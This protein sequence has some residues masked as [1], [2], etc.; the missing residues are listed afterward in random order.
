[1]FWYGGVSPQG[2]LFCVSIRKPQHESHAY[3][4]VTVPQNWTMQFKVQLSNTFPKFS[5]LMYLLYG[6]FCRV[7]ARQTAVHFSL[8][9]ICPT[10]HVSSTRLHKTV[11]GT[12]QAPFF[13][14]LL[15]QN[16]WPALARITLFILDYVLVWFVEYFCIANL[17]CVKVCHSLKCY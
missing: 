17:E 3:A 7:L 14:K 16:T 10:R 8:Y 13:Y 1:M 4:S 15:Y 12:Q 11:P 9:L 5:F 6:K 2:F